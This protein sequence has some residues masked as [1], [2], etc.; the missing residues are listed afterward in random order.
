MSFPCS[1]NFE[2][3]DHTFVM[4]LCGRIMKAQELASMACPERFEKIGFASP[5]ASI[6]PV[7]PNFSQVASIPCM[8]MLQICAESFIDQGILI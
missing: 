2:R 5:R 8:H 6:G 3:A 7:D 4:V 1:H